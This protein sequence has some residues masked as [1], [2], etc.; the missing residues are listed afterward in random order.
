MNLIKTFTVFFILA[1]S[2]ATVQAQQTAVELTDRSVKI[3]P[4]CSHWTEEKNVPAQE[5]FQH[6][7]EDWM[8]RR[9]SYPI[10]ALKKETQ[11]TVLIHYLIDEKGQFSIQ[12]VEGPS[13]LAA[14]GK[15]I[16]SGFPA[17]IPAKDAKGNPIAV[18][19]TYP[20]L[21]EMAFRQ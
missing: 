20:I 18:K 10:E 13:A 19:G 8:A 9:F 4:I 1:G 3:P 11:G 2:I 17:V 6:C 15:R 7:L 12:K 16:F 5:A 21:F 14:E